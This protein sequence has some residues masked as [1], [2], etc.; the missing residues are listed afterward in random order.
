VVVHDFR[1]LS[2]IEASD[3]AAS[4]AIWIKVD[5][6]MHRLGFDPVMIPELKS[7]LSV[8]PALRIMGWMTH[9][10]CADDV[11]NAM[12]S[13]QVKCLSAALGSTP[14]D[15]SIANSAGILAWPE[16]HADWVR[17]GIMLY[18]TSPF[19]DRT[20]LAIGL[21]PVMTLKSRLLS[22]RELPKGECIGYG[23]TWKTPE[24]MR[25]GVASIG[26]GDGYPRHAPSGTPV[27]VN[28][29]PAPLI[30]RVS[31]DFISLDLRGHD[32]ACEGDEVTLWGVDLPA[33]EVAVHAQTISYQLF[34][35]VSGRVHFE[36]L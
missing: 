25:V 5:T 15:R 1:Q 24:P 2:F 14:G 11:A 29:R 10:A 3:C 32:A 20:A 30:G 8:K 7:R 18:G 27:L 31:M 28:G 6:G 35:G 34:C 19:P 23:C 4:A 36:Y 13:A 22:I 17:P 21:R 12:T 9:L 16:T 26:Y 33:D